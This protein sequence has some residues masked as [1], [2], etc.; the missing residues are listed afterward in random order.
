MGEIVKFV[1]VMFIFLFI[2]LV[3]MNADAAPKCFENSD[4]PKDYCPL[5]STPWCSVGRCIKPRCSEGRCTC[6]L[7]KRKNSYD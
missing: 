6:V 4:C 2:L 3:A 7:K 1:C 5:P